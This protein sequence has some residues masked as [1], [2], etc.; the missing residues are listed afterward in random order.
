MCCRVP[1][2]RWPARS[3]RAAWG[4]RGGPSQRA[5]GRLEVHPHVVAGD[6]RHFAVL[7]DEDLRK[8]LATDGLE[9]RQEAIV[10][11]AQRRDDLGPLASVAR[12]DLVV[13]VEEP[14]GRVDVLQPST[15]AL[16]DAAANVQ[17]DGGRTGACR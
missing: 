11:L 13:Y 9:G 14:V 3:L 12:G 8:P 15:P 6:G 1:E 7:I 2:C 10:S 4:S 17:I 5:I 16:F